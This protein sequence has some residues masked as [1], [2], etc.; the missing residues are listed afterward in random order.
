MTVFDAPARPTEPIH[1][2]RPELLAVGVMIWLGSEFMFFSGLFAAFFT[3]RAHATVWPPPGTKLD[4]YQALLNDR[5][6]FDYS[7]ILSR[8]V[9]ELTTNKGLREHLAKLREANLLS[10]TKQ[11]MW[12]ALEIPSFDAMVE[13]ENRQQV[14]TSATADAAEAMASYTGGRAA[15]YRNR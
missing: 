3:I 11:G 9:V 2:A 4:T 14:L 10:L 1:P 5:R 13:V 6:Y 12:L 8:A 7:E 15:D